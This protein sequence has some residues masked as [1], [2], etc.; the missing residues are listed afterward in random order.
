MVQWLQKLFILVL[1]SI[2]LGLEAFVQIEKLKHPENHQSKRTY[3]ITYF[4]MPNTIRTYYKFSTNVCNQL[5][6]F[7]YIKH[8]MPVI[9]SS[10]N[11]VPGQSYEIIQ[12]FFMYVLR[13]NRI[14]LNSRSIL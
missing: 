7:A 9:V 5:Y 13:S 12:L 1:I 11:F 10:F 8:P 14:L 2:L 6:N 3:T 4:E